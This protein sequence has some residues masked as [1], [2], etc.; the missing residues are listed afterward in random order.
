M[1]PNRKGS[2]PISPET[3]TRYFTPPLPIPA[4]GVPPETL[5]EYLDPSRFPLTTRPNLSARQQFQADAENL[6]RLRAYLRAGG[7][8][9]DRTLARLA[10]L[11]AKEIARPAL[12][13]QLL[14][15]AGRN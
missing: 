9:N 12:L 4:V 5:A 2:R 14:D 7:T 6:K 8:S 10:E 3:I 13:S 1:K 15:L 11:E